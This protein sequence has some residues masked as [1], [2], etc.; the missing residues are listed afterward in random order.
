MAAKK[1]L[2]LLLATRLIYAQAVTPSFEVA[3]IKPA[4]PSPDGHV[5]IYYPP[6]DRF[7]AANITLLAL[8]QWAYSMPDRQI[9]DGPAWLSSTRFDIQA[10][11]ESSDQSKKLTSEEESELKRRLVQQLLVERCNLKIHQESRVLPAY[12]LVLAKGGSKLQESKA[13]GR[14]ISASRGSFH[15]EGLS[16]T[17]IAQELSRITGRIVVDKT[18]LSGVYDLKLRWTPDD[19][20]VADSEFPTLFTAIQEQLGLKL[21]SAKESVPVLV[22]EHMDLPSPN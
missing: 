12:D 7:S 5:H 4:A 21:E 17:L 19:A 6:G 20:A 18:G 14:S 9:V 2:L 8:M 22:I 1:L 3:T 11:A 16:M 10:K 13:N 15:A